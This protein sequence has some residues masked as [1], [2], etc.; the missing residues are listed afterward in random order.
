MWLYYTYSFLRSSSGFDLVRIDEIR[1]FAYTSGDTSVKTCRVAR[2]RRI[3]AVLT[4]EQL[5]QL[6]KSGFENIRTKFVSVDTRFCANVVH[7]QALV[8]N[9]CQITTQ[10]AAPFAH[11]STS[12]LEN[13]S[14]IGL[15]NY[16]KRG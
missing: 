7:V 15:V 12:I 6:P 9:I 8:R 14:D 5:I 3:R 2:Y 10:R 11:L 4:G 16:P 1:L 13:I